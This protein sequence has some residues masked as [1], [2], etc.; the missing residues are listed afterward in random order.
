MRIGDPGVTLVSTMPAGVHLAMITDAPWIEVDVQLTL[1]NMKGRGGAPALASFE[2]VVDGVVTSTVSCAE[3]HVITVDPASGGMDFAKGQPTTVR[4][5]GWP[6]EKQ[7]H[8]EV[9]LPHNAGVDLI[10]VRV[11]QHAQVRTNPEAGPRWAHYGSSISHC[12]NIP[13]PTQ[14]W[15]AVVARRSGASLYNL[16]FSS[17][18]HL[19]PAISHLLKNT[20][21]DA[22]SMK[23]GINVL[24]DDS[25]RERVFGPIV[26]GFLDAVRDG[27]PDIPIVV[28][29]PIFC[30]AL[31]DNPGPIRVTVD[32]GLEVVPRDGQLGVGALT[33]LR[34]RELLSQVVSLRAKTDGHLTFLDGTELLGPSDE[35]YL[36]DGLHPDATGTALIGERFYE[37]T[38]G[39]GK[40]FEQIAAY[41]HP[42]REAEGRA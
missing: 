42:G 3:G 18:C 9:W 7:H 17:G 30:R 1:L 24:T 4:L 40:P 15:P 23:V 39:P 31:E 27:H 29:S 28:I 20:A 16:G 32:N 26:H 14:T 19:D 33:G 41:R 12:F 10:D 2:A 36:T 35:I 5:E 37:Q 21:I 6:G 11:P 25:M 13:R 38:F 22:L 8:L 34:V